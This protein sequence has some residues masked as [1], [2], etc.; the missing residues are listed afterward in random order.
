MSSFSACPCCGNTEFSTST[1]L[2]QSLIDEWRLASYEVDYINRQQGLHCEKCDSSL[3]SMALAVTIMKCFGYE[4]LF[5]DFVL[6]EQAQQLKILEINE[7]GQLTSFFSQIPGHVLVCY[8][9][10]NIM[11]M[12]FADGSFDLVVHS[13]TLE[14]I[15]YPIKA[16]SECNRILKP[17]TFL[18]FTVP[19]I[20]DRLTSSR[21]GLPPSYHAGAEDI[22]SVLVYTEYGCDAWKHLIQAGFNEC[23]IYSIDYPAA[24]VL[25]GVKMVSAYIDNIDEQLKAFESGL[26]SQ[27]QQLQAQLEKA[28]S[29]IKLM[30]S[31]VELSRSQLQHT[32]A[33]LTQTLSS[34]EDK[35]VKLGY[36]QTKI[37]NLE[38]QLQVSQSERENYYNQLALTRAEVLWMKSSKLWKLKEILSAFKDLVRQQKQF[39]FHI[40]SPIIQETVCSDFQI[41]GW[42]ISTDGIGIKAVRAKV[43]KKTFDG[44][45]GLSRLDVVLSHSDVKAAEISGFQISLHLAPGQYE[46]KLEVQDI[47]EKWHLLTSHPV[48]VSTLEIVL[49]ELSPSQSNAKNPNSRTR[50][51]KKIKDLGKFANVVRKQALDKLREKKRVSSLQ[52]IL[53]TAR[54]IKK[55]Y[56]QQFGQMSVVPDVNFVA[57]AKDAY[58]AWLDVNQ[59][60]EKA[61][62]HLR[63]RLKTC[64]DLP[65]ISVV[66]PV[67]NPQVR[68]LELAIASVVNQVYE[69]WELCIADD[70]STDP[71][72]HSTLNHWVAKDQRI[73][74]IFREQNGNISAATNSA[75]SLAN[76]DFLLFLDHDDELSPDALGEVALCL[77][78]D[79]KTDFLY[80]DDDKIDT[81]GRRF[82][83]QFKPDWSPEL[84][85][86]YMYLSHL[87]TVRR[88]IFESI[89][90]LRVGFEGSQDYDFALRAT[91]ISRQVT[92]LP[93][94]LYHWRAV[95]GSTAVS[96][97][98]KPAS[99]A[100]AQK[101]LQEA[102]TRRNILGYVSQPE[103]AVKGAVGIFEHEFPDTG[104]SVTIIIPTKNKVDL[105]RKCVSSL[106]KTTYQNY[107]IV[108][109]DNESDDP[110]TITYLES[111]PHKVLRIQ[112]PETGFNFAA[113]NNRAAE[114]VNSDY[115][116]FLNNDTEVISSSWLSQMMG[117][118][119]F[120]GV[121][122]VGAR[123]LYPDGR[124]QHAGVV[125]GLH[126]GLV[127]HALKLLPNWDHGYLSYA[128]VVRNYSALTAACLLTP[129]QLF[130]ELEGFD[131]QEFAVAYNDV[132]YCYRLLA[133]N[134]R[135]VYC[136]KAE[137]I[138]YE[139]L[140]RGFMDHPQEKFAYRQKY[141]QK[142][143]SFYSPHLSLD[144]EQFQI[145][146]RRFFRGEVPPLKVLICSNA[147]NL[148]GAPNT[149]YE[150]A[151]NLAAQGKIKPI[152]FS[153]SD[154]PLRQAYEEQGIEVIIHEHPLKNGYNIEAYERSIENLQKEIERQQI[155]VIYA[156]T[157]ESFF[158]IDCARILNI[159]CV[160]NVHE[161]E[162]WQT[163][164]NHY[165]FQIAKRALEC[166]SVPYQIIFGSDATRNLYVPLNSRNNFTVIH[167]VL[168]LNRLTQAASKWQRTEARR[169]LGVKKNETV[170]LLLGTVCD[171]KGQQ[172][173]I[174]AI[175]H[176]PK[177]WQ[178]QIKCF[179]VGDRPNEYSHKLHKMVAALP[180]D[181]RSQIT[182]VPETLEAAKYYTAADIFVCTS[183]IECYPRVIL[184]AMAYGL[185]IVS[186]AV[187]GIKEQI[188]DGV[189]GIFYPLGSPEDLTDAI[190]S[191]LQDDTLRSRLAKNSHYVLGST[192]TFEEMLQTYAQIFREAYFTSQQNAVVSAR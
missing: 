164:F 130:L 157:L 43:G 147:L 59:W 46:I 3:R 1:V 33:E 22:N 187:F 27:K 143:D 95:P 184:E 118:A 2:W 137:L 13:D 35:Q 117:Y 56:R 88:T 68:F 69:N 47:L 45:Y 125:H 100:A 24:Q 180:Q 44:T 77:T 135:C 9:E 99:F 60:N 105:L 50:W 36:S 92:H 97:A 42:C 133:N 72:V 108:I 172:E 6:T 128:K 185:P 124:I 163:Y 14:H 186:T 65:K 55:L 154:G 91:E 106:E 139:G 146:A 112:N 102:L 149:Q 39:L 11:Q 104:P 178:G 20:V 32:Q 19:M 67:Y 144:N 121:G 76:G 189:N 94:V 114:Q 58:E 40:D 64:Q 103:W 119:Q 70:C 156:N 131:E 87:C 161:S 37:K 176:L 4:G 82:A 7:A 169:S 10:V 28:Q 115:L 90:G 49:S 5:K 16:L 57:Q 48:T 155:D 73:R 158:N 120:E 109:I 29:Q 150:I 166:F 183:R 89:G 192:I 168:D 151:V 170:L 123:L 51:G 132:D 138:H 179:I 54:W 182:L 126:H 12:P 190:L 188:Q 84:L 71:A 141:Y 26:R 140:S 129:R 23:R 83:P 116:L 113:I 136:P 127:G 66:M 171:R 110:K 148:T 63:N 25:V 52:D 17:G 85:L 53:K 160:W 173:L 153:V 61:S 96:G 18:A 181:L 122:A 62:N 74:V 167:S 107:Q 134:Y 98:A 75:A 152:V 78:E 93:L 79:P 30:H 80:S 101:A 142:L 174:Q 8:P 81:V 191:L 177:K 86:S 41:I 165:G 31:E 111:L 38:A 21:E 175:S 34:I 159:P 145:Q 162:P 15:Q